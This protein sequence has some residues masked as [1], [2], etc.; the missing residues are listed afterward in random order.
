M[1]MHHSFLGYEMSRPYFSARAFT[2]VLELDALD[3]GLHM[4]HP[5]HDTNDKKPH[6]GRRKAQGDE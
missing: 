3:V 4:W 1:D 5:L 6:I 2:H